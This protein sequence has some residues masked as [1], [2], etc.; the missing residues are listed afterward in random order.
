[1][2]RNLSFDPN[3]AWFK[4]QKKTYTN[5]INARLQES[6]ES[7]HLRVNDVLEDLSGEISLCQATR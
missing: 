1:M 7:S 6:E 2:N 3:A 4:A 5:W